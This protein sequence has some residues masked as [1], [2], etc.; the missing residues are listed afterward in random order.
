MSDQRR[1]VV[2]V[3]DLSDGE[4]AAHLA[5]LRGVAVE[6]GWHVA[7]AFT[8]TAPSRS[9]RRLGLSAL[10]NVIRRGDLGQI[11]VVVSC[12]RSPEAA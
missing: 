4:V 9:R 7:A 2:Y 12:R 5:E 11:T 8:D 10:L 6:R 1:V 3:R